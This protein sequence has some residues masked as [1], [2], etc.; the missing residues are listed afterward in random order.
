M[1][2]RPAADCDKACQKKDWPHHKRTCVNKLADGNAVM[3]PFV[4]MAADGGL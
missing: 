1:N 4:Y 2:P 3:G